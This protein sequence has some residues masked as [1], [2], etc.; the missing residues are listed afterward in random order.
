M[1]DYTIL[2]GQFG[3]RPPVTKHSPAFLQYMGEAGIRKMVSDHYDTLVKS[4][5]SDLFPN[6]GPALEE[7]KKHSADFIMQ[8][9]GGP[10]YFTQSRGAPRMV[11]RHEPFRIDAHARLIWLESY[12]EQ[13]KNLK[14]QNGEDLPDPI[15]QEFFNYINVFSLWMVNTPS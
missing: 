7:A 13:I 6:E 5:I 10:A 3:V 14:D 8:I 9:S 1:V 15:K 11:G 12:I 2:Q 4:E